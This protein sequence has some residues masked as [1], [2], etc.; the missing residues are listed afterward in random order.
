MRLSNERDQSIIKAAIGDASASTISFL[1]AIGNRE[2]IVFGEGVS[3]TMRMRFETQPRHLLP[4]AHGLTSGTTWTNG[5]AARE[6]TVRDILARM[7]SSGGEAL[8]H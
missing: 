8:G 5:Q 6:L 2:A 7:R 4:S 1:S 3:T